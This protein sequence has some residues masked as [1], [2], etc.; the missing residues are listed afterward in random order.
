MKQNIT[1]L[2]RRGAANLKVILLSTVLIC[3]I[4]FSIGLSNN[5]LAQSLKGKVVGKL[6]DADTGDPLIGANVIIEG[7]MIGAAADLEGNYRILHVPPGSYTLLVRMMGYATT[8]ITGVI[9]NA[10]EITTINASLKSEILETEGVVVTAKAIRNTESLLLK[11]R[12]KAIAVSDAISAEAI[13]QAGAGNA[14]EAVKQITGASVVDGKY[15]YVRGLGDRYTSTQLNGAS[16]PSTDPYKRSGSIDL[17][18]TNLIDNIVTVKSFT[19]NKPGDFSGGTVDIR[20]KDFPEELKIDFS[21]SASYNTNTTFND[22]KNTIGYKGGN[23]DWLGFDDGSRNVPDYI[24]TNGVPHYNNA[25]AANLLQLSNATKEFS[26]QMW[27]ES[28]TPSLNQGYSLSIGNQ[29]DLFNRPFGFIGSLTYSNGFSAYDNGQYNAWNLLEDSSKVLNQLYT[30]NHYNTT[31]EVLWG[32]LLKGSYK[33][34]SNDIVSFNFI[35]NVNGTSSADY[36]E[37]HYE[38]DKLDSD[39]LHQNHVL[40][41]SERRLTSLQFNGDH[42]FEKFF[43]LSLDWKACIAKTKQDEPDLRYFTTYTMMEDGEEL[44]GVFTNLVPQRY[45]HYLNEDNNE[46]S[47]NFDFPFEQWAGKKSN[48]KFGGLYSQKNRNFEELNYSYSAYNG[49]YGDPEAYFSD[50]NMESD[51]SVVVINGVPWVTRDLNLYIEEGDIG[52]NDYSGEKIV[53]AQ[54]LMVVLPITSKLRFIG[55]AR[56]EKTNMELISADER[57]EDGNISTE[58]LLPSANFIYNLKD[59]MNLRLSATRSLARPTLR[60]LAP[61]ASYDFVVGFTAIGNPD[62]KR[63]LIDNYDIRWEWFSR[64]GEIYAVSAFY[65]NFQDPI[66]RAFVISASNREITWKNV[67][68]AKTMGIEFEVR[69]KLDIISPNLGNFMIGTNLSL[70]RSEVQIPAGELALIRVK[71]PDFKDTRELEGQSPFLL[72]FNM[73][74]DNLNKGV[75]CNIYYNVFGERLS[76]V[77]KDGT[78][79]VYEQ[80]VHTLNANFS[81]RIAKNIKFKLSGKNLLDAEFKKTHEYEGTEYIFRTYTKGRTF[82]MGFA[83]S[84]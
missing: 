27:T 79:F 47:V 9:V 41:F 10:G 80:P 56:Y 20:T 11:D 35:Y 57:K 25:S 40:G 17:V 22:G 63:T 83:Y 42:Q 81:L 70:V 51:S 58:D 75:F 43:G 15:V 24:K 67:D 55:G 8:R 23:L 1:R 6:V 26:K 72:N 54:Y 59:N 53:N 65:K 77:S 14:A 39:D 37:G 29:I 38:Y 45:Y 69:K 33:L 18:P 64:P 52:A 78:P 50:D 76:E 46:F 48:L 60:E 73:S 68:Q 21:T 19:P 32:T 2:H 4:L 74:Y 82:S 16:I 7:T 3:S 71:R 5:L 62:L 36:Y 61:Y 12:Q 28:I 30:Y 44:P 49:Y 31:H 13:S 84:L 34:T 66:E